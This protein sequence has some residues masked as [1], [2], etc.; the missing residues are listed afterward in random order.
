MPVLLL[1]LW[2]TQ[3]AASSDDL[4]DA[5][6]AG[7]RGR[8]AQILDAG[9]DVNARAR[10]DATALMFAA[11]KG[12]LEAV[13]LLADRG[14]DVNALDT[15]YRLRAI[16]LALGNG[17]GQVARF[18]L[19]R[20]SRGAANALDAGIRE[21]D[22]GLVR[23]A[24]AT[25]ELE[26]AT[27]AAALVV[28][29]RGSNAAIADLVATAAA[30]RPL[31]AASPAVTVPA[32]TLQSYVGTYRND[33]LDL[34]A[35]VGSADDALTVTVG[36]QPPLRFVPTSETVFSAASVP[37]V[38][39]AFEGRAGTVEWLLLNRSGQRTRLARVSATATTGAAPAR[40][41]APE[42]TVP[43]AARTAAT[44]W[45]SFRGR[46]ASGVADAKGEAAYEIEPGELHAR[47]RRPAPGRRF[48]QYR[49]ARRGRRRR[50]AAVAARHWRD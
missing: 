33:D 1:L 29:K 10:Y 19:E 8:I 34:T 25:T 18:L 49:F 36:A 21:G 17:H 38:T 2:L 43:A 31:V 41:S 26:P 48:R 44:P 16:D 20:G 39:V 13:R 4:F 32:A 35:T 27:L 23:A 28:A 9:V 47:D 50:H 5:A 30:A 45:P 22:E 42:L 14:A 12:H 15:F 6:R 7:D 3:P 46:N 37:N 40:P 24:L 11:D